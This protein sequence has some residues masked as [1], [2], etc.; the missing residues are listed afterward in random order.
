MF[1]R[2]LLGY[3]C[4]LYHWCKWN[5]L[6]RITLNHT[7]KFRQGNNDILGVKKRI[8]LHIMITWMIMPRNMINIISA[9]ISLPCI[10]YAGCWT[11]DCGSSSKLA[12]VLGHRYSNSHVN[13]IHKSNL[14]IPLEWRHNG[15]DG[16]SNHQPHVC[17]LNRFF[18]RRSQKTSKLRVTGLCAGN[19]PVT[20]EFPA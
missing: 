1:L 16:V 17:L 14:Y 7:L 8:A 18:K 3:Q 6:T 20:G 2:L 12:V 19:S 11:Q 5:T 13:Q 15:F 10:S 4:H 9:L